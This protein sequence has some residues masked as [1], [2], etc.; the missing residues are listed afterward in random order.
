MSGKK[1]KALRKQ[2]VAE[3]T[4]WTPFREVPPPAEVDGASGVKFFVNSRYQVNLTRFDIEAPFGR[5]IH[6]SIKT[7]DRAPYH[8][9]RDFQRIK[10]E[11]I[12]PEYEA[13]ELYPAESRLVD[14]SN[15]YHLWCFTGFKF[16][17]G[18][19]NR[20]VSD[21]QEFMGFKYKQRPFENPPVD[22]QPVDPRKVLSSTYEEMYFGKKVG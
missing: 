7:L 20:E 22:N 2:S 6:L 13:V 10:N 9:W 5:C 18:Y 15:Q 16:P 11:L 12:G 21:A 1:E 8:D 17:F 19:R 14:T 4:P 3:K